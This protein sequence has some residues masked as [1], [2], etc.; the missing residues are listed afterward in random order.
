MQYY[1]ND[2]LRSMKE[3]INSAIKEDRLKPNEG[4]R[5]LAEYAGGLKNFRRMEQA[6]K[7]HPIEE[8]GAALRQ[9]MSWIKPAEKKSA[10]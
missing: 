5:L 6:D 8:V 9:R 4:M 10:A 1:P 3:Q 7:S 2:L